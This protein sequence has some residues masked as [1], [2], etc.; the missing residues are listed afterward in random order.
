MRRLTL[1][2]AAAALAGSASCMAADS[3][4]PAAPGPVALTVRLPRPSQQIFDVQEVMPVRPGPLTLYYPKWLPGDHSPDGPIEQ[5]MGLEI[6][7]GGKRIAWHRD[8][9]DMFT[10]HLSVPAGVDR[11]DVRFQFPADDRITP[12]LMG[13]AWNAVALYYA[14]YPTREELFQPTMVIPAA[15]GY[16]TALKTEARNG[17][18]VTFK[19]VPFN[20]LVDSPVIAGQYFREIDVTPAESPVHRYLDL[21]GDDAAAIDISAAQLAGYRRLVEQAQALFHS[22]HYDDYHFLLT[23]SDYTS[24]G[25]LEHHRSSDDRARSGA[26]MFA[27]ADHFMLDASLL[28]HEYTHSWNGKFMRPAQLWQPDF[29]RPEH[30]WGLWVYEGLTV[31]LGD[32]L[33]VRSGLWSPDTWRDVVAYRASAMTHRPGRDWRPLIDTTVGAQLVYGAPMRW[34]SWRRETDFYRE[35]QLLWLTVDMKIRTLSHDR[36]S[37]GDFAQRFFGVDDGSYVTR[38]YTFGDV[39]NALNAVQPYDWAG[40][41]HNWLDGVGGQVP[42]LSGIEASGWRLVYTDQPSRYQNAV[43]NVGEGELEAKGVNEMCSVGLF[44][45]GTGKVEDVLWGSPA[46]AAGLAPGMKLTSIDGRQYATQVLRGEIVRAQKSGMPLQIQADED[47]TTQLYTVHYDGGLKYP[48]LVRIPGST[49][50]LE[51]ILAPKTAG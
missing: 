49:D 38:T 41:L 30:G 48:H 21:V 7:A 14:G 45:D 19:T 43:E 32:M 44:L 11:I 29:E 37:I 10:F 4:A 13:L 46:F 12:H 39:V 17:G 47:G 51:R 1:L 27:D 28:P 6:T 18:R 20:T 16:A 26:K 34:S 31:Y 42:L 23:L 22:H 3:L 5:M 2:L 40:F 35:G 8:E 9:V 15:W 25:G 24:K 36:H 50:Y 33:T